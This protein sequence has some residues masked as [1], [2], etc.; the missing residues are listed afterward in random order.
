[1]KR[2]ILTEEIEKGLFSVPKKSFGV[3][4]EIKWQKMRQDSVRVSS[5]ADSRCGLPQTYDPAGAYLCAGREDGK[6]AACNKLQ[7]TECLIAIRVID[8]GHFQS[9]MYW[10]TENAGDPEARYCPKGKLQSARIGFGSTR[11]SEGFGCI[12]CEYSAPMPKDDSEGREY[13][14][15]LKGHPVEG[16][17]CCAEN[18]PRDSDDWTDNT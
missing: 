16:N 18:E 1:M 11:N 5:Y 4:D 14:C 9:C 17:A 8:D 15:K 3:D 10:E 12:R 7:G 13:W 6:S 2:P